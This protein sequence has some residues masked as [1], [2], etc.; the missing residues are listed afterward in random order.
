MKLEGQGL[1]FEAQARKIVV[2]AQFS[3]ARGE[4]VGLIG[5]NG[6]GK[7]T[8][9]RMLYRVLKPQH[10]KVL[11]QG[12][13][14]WSMS[15]R[16]FA[17]RVAVLAQD[18]GFDADMRVRDLVMT[19]RIPHQSHWA[20][21]SP[22]DRA[23]VDEALVRV[24]AEDLAGRL[25]ANLSGG[26]RQRVL[27]ARALAQQPRL[28]LLDEP[29]NHLDIR[30]QLEMMHMLK[31][32]GLSTVV[33]LHDLNMAASHCHRLYLMQAGRILCSGEPAT[34]LTADRIQAVYGVRADI[35]RHP[36]TGHLRITWLPL[37]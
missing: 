32:L 19:G 36:A 6:S 28:I 2:D 17:R 26:E 18:G 4:C 12:A 25:L 35:D 30:H 9:L 16:D 34:V 7:S 13:D 15:A 20:A 24:G 3:L 22:E 8:L 1:C 31:Q 11:L 37:S 5:P 29:T 27:L 14:V 21:D 33:A 10:G 23:A